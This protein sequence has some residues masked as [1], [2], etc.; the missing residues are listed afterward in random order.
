M[1]A[2]LRLIGYVLIASFLIKA[3]TAVLGQT[4]S[5]APVKMGGMV[6][7][8]PAGAATYQL[9]IQVSPGSNGLQP[10]LSIVYNSQAGNG[11][12]GYG[13]TLAGLSSITKEHFSPYYDNPSEILSL[14]DVG[15]R[16]ALDGVRLV[17]LDQNG[18][19]YHPANNP[20]VRVVYG[21]VSGSKI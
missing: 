3:Q 8:S 17:K 21:M 14:N 6:D 15:S 12:L 16:I 1:K 7:V 11:L 13:W 9:P 20:Y 5:N 2:I 19:I 10:A 18:Y 4:T